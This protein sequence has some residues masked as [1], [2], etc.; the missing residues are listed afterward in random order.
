MAIDNYE[1]SWPY[2]RFCNN[3]FSMH[4]AHSIGY[5]VMRKFQLHDHYEL[6]YI[7]KGERVFYINDHVFTGRPGDMIIIPPAMLHRTASSTRIQ[8][9]ERVLINIKPEFVE[10]GEWL[11]TED[12]NL[13]AGG[14]CLIRLPKEEQPVIEHIIWEML[15]ECKDQLSGCEK[16]L[17]ACLT[18]LLIR[19][20]RQTIQS[21]EKTPYCT[22]PMQ[23]KIGE[24]VMFIAVNYSEELTLKQLADKFY[25]SPSYLSRIFK[26]LTGF[27][28]QEY[29]TAVRIKESQKLLRE[30]Q[31]K[32]ID[33][34]LLTGFKNVAYFNTTFK[35]ITGITP[36]NY[37]K[38]Y[39][40]KVYSYTP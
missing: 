39:Y 5:R 18:R 1:S 17:K 29:I 23:E 32:M 14:Y 36:L 11:T 4:H 6:F 12:P 13:F 40:A 26:K 27:Q 10:T 33:I 7:L 16:Y 34:A 20:S 31:Y 38:N 21:G 24:I 2:Y 9:C 22:H 8:E 19:L 35:K 25:I 30:S 28:F 15:S 3:A 37:R